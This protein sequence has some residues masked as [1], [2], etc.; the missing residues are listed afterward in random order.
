MPS[1]VRNAQAWWE[2]EVISAGGCSSSSGG[3]SSAT[4]AVRGDQNSWWWLPVPGLLLG[5]TAPGLLCHPRRRPLWSDTS[6]LSG[7]DLFPLTLEEM[8]IS[9][10]LQHLRA[11]FEH[12]ADKSE[13][14]HLFHSQSVKTKRRVFPI[15]ATLHGRLYLEKIPSKPAFMGWQK[16]QLGYPLLCWLF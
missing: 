15:V 10:Q 2:I 9:S 3:H 1:A 5:T 8:A 12:K 11:V 7:F 4:V 6:E 14:L 13:Y 16:S